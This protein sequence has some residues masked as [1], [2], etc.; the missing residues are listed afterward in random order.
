MYLTLILATACLGYAELLFLP[1][2]PFFLIPVGLLLVAAFFLEGRWL[3]PIWGANALGLAITAGTV[4]W[5][6]Y[7]YVQ[8]L[9]GADF[10]GGTIPW[11]AALLPHVGPLLMLL[12]LIKLFRPKQDHDYWL[13]QT[14]GFLEVALACVLAGEMLFGLLLFSYLAC[15]LW[16]LSL[17]QLARL[18]G[19]FPLQDK[20]ESP[21][22]VG[23]DNGNRR[24]VPQ[25]VP[26]RLL[27]VGKAC[28]WALTAGILGLVLFLLAPRQID[29]V[30][31]ADR[32][33]S[34]QNQTIE[35]GFT[36]DM[37]LNRTGTVKLSEAI[38]FEVTV[39]DQERGGRPRLDLSPGQRWRGIA[40]EQY[41]RGRWHSFIPGGV[42]QEFA[43]PIG[44]APAMPMVKGSHHHLHLN[45]ELPALGANQFFIT[46]HV[47]PRKAH[48]LFLADP[49]TLGPKATDH[50]YKC[51]A[52]PGL[53]YRF[54]LFFEM[55]GNLN[56][57]RQRGGGQRSYV[58]VVVPSPPGQEDLSVPR[59]LMDPSFRRMEFR[60][61]PLPEVGRWTAELLERL[62]DEDRYGL[63][64]AHCQ[65]DANNQLAP[66]FRE[67]VARALNGYLAA[68]GEFRYTLDLRR[69]DRRL[70]PTDDFLRNVKRGHCELFASALALMLRSHGIPTRVVKGF[71]GAEHTENGRYVVRKSQAHSWVE[72]LVPARGMGGRQCW[73]TLDPTPAEEA[74]GQGSYSWGHVFADLLYGLEDLWRSFLVEFNPDAQRDTAVRLSK[75]LANRLDNLGSWLADSFSGR[76]WTKGGFWIVVLTAGLIANRL[77]RRLR[78]RAQAQ[79]RTV[80][81]VAFYARL[82]TILR[83]RCRLCPDPAQTPREFGET[84]R[85]FL[86]SRS[87][88]EALA[89]LPGRVAELFYQVRFGHKVV[90]ETA[91]R[92]LEMQLQQLDRTLAAT[93]SVPP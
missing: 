74:D 71:R 54:Q 26:W 81:G 44:K 45:R 42:L 33:M 7:L 70:D 57:L 17:Y 86:T 59:W 39:T 65:L 47:D 51:L 20:P 21:P 12:L 49:V 30:W 91:C 5:V 3:I 9:E 88:P 58:Q 55:D 60:R 23:M 36:A 90:D 89:E 53:T 63:T 11:P 38:A 87:A 52:G 76:F 25:C 43:R 28:L 64:A 72:A 46:Y 34:S 19:R 66:E 14:I 78:R 32:L 40:L 37:D 61:R 35:V 22:L 85:Q 68:S 73:L 18:R 62:A 15:G 31:D 77:V 79:R 24:V 50:P 29:T 93:C 27:G 84:A 10:S 2:M 4:A 67:D 75:Y 8:R 48:G 82:L 13:L 1:F 16:S 80:P 6:R 92:T 69:H 83:C 41:D 56:V